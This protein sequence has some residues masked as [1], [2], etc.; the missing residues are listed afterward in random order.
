MDYGRIHPALHNLLV[1]GEEKSPDSLLDVVKKKIEERDIVCTT[2]LDIRWR[3]LSGKTISK[4]TR[5]L[6]SKDVSIFHVNNHWWLFFI[7]HFL[8]QDS[9]N[10]SNL[11]R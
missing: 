4:E 9:I 8:F 11:F 6:L 1:S 2:D 7:D 3:L 5:L 10:S